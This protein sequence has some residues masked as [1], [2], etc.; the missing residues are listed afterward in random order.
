MKHFKHPLVHAFMLTEDIYLH[1]EG[2]KNRGKGTVFIAIY[3]S[4]PSKPP[5]SVLFINVAVHVVQD[6][7]QERGQSVTNKTLN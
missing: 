6:E 5:H 2:Q 1:V 4:L 7:R 3:V